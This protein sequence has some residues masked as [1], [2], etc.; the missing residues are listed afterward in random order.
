MFGATMGLLS[1]CLQ[2]I[3]VFLLKGYRYL[4]S[5]FLGIGNC[6]RFQPSCSEYAVIAV[7]QLPLYRG[8]VLVLWRLLRCHPFC[9]GGFDPVPLKQ[10]LTSVREK[11][12]DLPNEF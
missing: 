5:P 3:I 12:R 2:K 1:E 9:A 6:C 7:Q 10:S 8:L 11:S 4:I